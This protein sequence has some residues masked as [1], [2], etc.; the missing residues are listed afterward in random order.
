MKFKS[1]LVFVGLSLLITEPSMA[2]HMRSKDSLF[3]FLFMARKATSITQ[4]DEKRTD[5]RVRVNTTPGSVG[6]VSGTQM[7]QTGGSTQRKADAVTYEVTSSQDIDSAMGEVL[8]TAGI[9]YA[10]YD[11]VMINGHGPDPAVIKPEF[12]HK[13][14]LS[15]QTRAKII[16]AARKCDVRY[17]ATGT[18][19]IGV[20]DVD[21]VS[22]NRRVYVSVRANLWDIS[23]TLPRKVG[24][25]GP[26]Q[27]SGLG[28]DQSVASRNALIIAAKETALSLVD[29]LNAKGV[30]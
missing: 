4:F 18:I 27:F 23:T 16:N 5:V 26:V 12:V 29:Q 19:D 17:L 10:A 24:S 15:A 25:V 3:T 7:E 2:E 30:R 14:D 1:L 11:D 8:T 13:D 22:G 6:F 20:N 9:E 28:P 21:P